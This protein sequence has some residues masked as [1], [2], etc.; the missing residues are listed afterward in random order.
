MAYATKYRFTFD[1]VHG[2]E[3]Q[4][5]IQ[6]DGY[7]GDIIDRSLGRAPVLKRRKNGP[8]CGTSLEIYAECQVDG[9]FVEFYTSNPR[10]Y[11][12]LLY[13][14]VTNIWSGFI[15]PELYSEPSIAPPYD[16]EI[17]ANDG[18][19][20]LKLYEYPASG[21]VSIQSILRTLLSQTGLSFNIYFAGQ[22]KEAGAT[23]TTIGFTR[24][25][26][27][28][29][30]MAGKTY[31][32]VLTRLLESLHM[33]ITQIDKGWLLARETDVE[34]S[35]LDSLDD[36]VRIKPNG[37]ID[38]VN[39]TS[40][41]NSAGQMGVA[42]MWPIG[43][44]ST[45][46][47]PAKRS[48][49]ITMP[50]QL[51]NII[52][53]P[54][55][56][57]PSG[58]ATGWTIDNARAT[59]NGIEIG[60]WGTSHQYTFGKAYQWIALNKLTAALHISAKVFGETGSSL[61]N[62]P[63]RLACYLQWVPDNGGQY[64]YFYNGQWTTTAPTVS[65]IQFITPTNNGNSLFASK[66]AASEYKWDVPPTSAN[67]SGQLCVVFC[68]DHIKLYHAELEVNLLNKGY[69]DTIK[70]DNGARGDGDD[71]EI[72]GGRFASASECISIDAYNGILTT[73]ATNPMACTQF[74]D[75]L[76]SNKDFLSITALGY[77]ES[78]ALPRFRTT[79]KLDV[80]ASMAT[81]PLLIRTTQGG[82]TIDSWIETYEW[83]LLNDELTI[84][85][86]SL[87]V[88]V[89][90]VESETIKEIH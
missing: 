80:P 9:E 7:S 43:Y 54:D 58:V 32:D 2:V 22:I 47:E 70:I 79:G 86:L 89:L 4:I 31:Y 10:E 40:V 64:Y 46:I 72:V 74:S 59:G 76:F 23:A 61:D 84:S 57:T 81:P 8:I 65:T 50:W 21:R 88:A 20:E 12:V 34:V 68:G 13:R 36:V 3:H 25:G 28:M 56:N 45:K 42:D 85:A 77:A 73:W 55:I 5:L 30:F 90:D 1:S 63:N 6:Q 62:A 38:E 19:G 33:T 71:V 49:K 41:V 75:R 15:T 18:L 39:L 24:L 87:P 29:D 48:V 44:M 82:T 37:T 83:D 52:Q 11:R 51:V 60:E 14:G 27:N 67:T 35:Q 69:E 26:I 16:V 53:N 78:V 66:D 17:V